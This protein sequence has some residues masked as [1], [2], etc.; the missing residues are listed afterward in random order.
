[1]GTALGVR[2]DPAQPHELELGKGRDT[3]RLHGDESNAE[4]IR[5][6]EQG[7]A[8]DD[9]GGV[10]EDTSQTPTPGVGRLCARRR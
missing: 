1:L 2:R 4:R 10:A 6:D 5:V 7:Q 3:D 9:P 8:A